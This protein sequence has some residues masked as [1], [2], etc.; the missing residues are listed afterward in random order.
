M[1]AA[2][3]SPRRRCLLSGSG[4]RVL[5]VASLQVSQMKTS[6]TSLS[7]LVSPSSWSWMRTC[8]PSGLTSSWAT[9]RLSKQPLR[10]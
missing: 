9:R 3:M 1:P 10:K 7:P 5:L 6:S 2:R 8:V 4:E